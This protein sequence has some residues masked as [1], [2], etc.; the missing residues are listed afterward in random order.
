ME[1]KDKL[2]S[3]RVT[4]DELRIIR[5]G[6]GHPYLIRELLL[7]EAEKNIKRKKK[8]KRGDDSESISTK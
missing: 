6:F 3:I 4:R 5:E 7:R 8:L 1:R 2:L